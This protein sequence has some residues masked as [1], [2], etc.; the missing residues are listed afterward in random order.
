MGKLVL[1]FLFSGLNIHR[2]RNGA[3]KTLNNHVLDGVKSKTTYSK[4]EQAEQAEQSVQR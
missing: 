4:A 3:H 1:P 2:F